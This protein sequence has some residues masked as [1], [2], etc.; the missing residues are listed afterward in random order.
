MDVQSM[1]QSLIIGQSL[2]QQQFAA[3]HAEH[4]RQLAAQQAEHQSTIARL[5]DNLE[6][7]RRSVSSHGDAQ[8]PASASPH[9]E[10]AATP[11][12]PV[13]PSPS[14]FTA[15]SSNPSNTAG[16]SSPLRMQTALHTELHASAF[17]ATSSSAQPS[18]TADDNLGPAINTHVDRLIP[19]DMSRST[20]TELHQAKLIPGFYVVKDILEGPR[21]DG[22]FHVSWHHT[23]IT[24]WEPA[25]SLHHVLRF[26]EFC[27]RSGLNSK[28]EKTQSSHCI[29]S[30]S[31]AS[32]VS[33]T[34]RRSR[35]NRHDT[36]A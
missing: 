17:H 33:D 34:L 16:T 2:M 29:T 22:H 9:R 10:P 32:Q 18:T 3:Q 7:L 11:D 23:D 28:G 14:A 31:Q 4:Q 5:Q 35:R 1:F 25:H 30:A 8:A 20:S 6:Q 26:Q 19:Y 12:H 27:A 15:A 36:S 24:T 21:N 13:R